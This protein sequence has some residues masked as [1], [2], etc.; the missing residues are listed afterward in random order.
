MN[1]RAELRVLLPGALAGAGSR[2]AGRRGGCR[3]RSP[4]PPPADGSTLDHAPGA[5]RVGEDDPLEGAFKGGVVAAHR[6]LGSFQRSA[7][8]PPRPPRKDCARMALMAE[9]PTVLVIDD[10][11][12]S[13]ESMAIALEKAGYRVRTF[14]DARK[15]LELPRRGPDSGRASRSATSRCRAWTA[16]ASSTRSARPAIRL[17]R[18]PGHRLR[19]AS[20]RRSRRCG[21]APTTTSPSRSTSTS[22]AH[23]S[24][25]LLEKEQLQA[26]RSATSGAMLDKRYGFESIIGSSAP[27][28]Q[29]F[30]QMR[31]VAP[32]RSTRARRRRERHRQGA[33][34]QRAPPREPAAQRA[35]PGD[36]LRRDP[37]RHPGERAVRPRARRLHRRG[38]A[39]DRQVRAGAPRHAV[40][41]RDRRALPGAPGQAPARARGAPGHAGRRQR[42]DRRRRPAD[43]RHQ[44]RPRAGGRRTG[45]SARTSTTGS[46]W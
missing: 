40:P 27:M 28:E 11:T 8:P 6:F 29:L 31:M 30:E 34:R 39:Q 10:E 26:R 23:G 19:L 43:R 7:A 35:L 38:D 2:P 32:T 15:A 12:G 24:T 45:A 1:W 41:R 4:V 37:E 16:W 42:A 21:S 14:D 5:L 13:R 17:R 44:P 18:D 3:P 22:C 36:Q 20:T 33:G 9:N 25:N 46:R